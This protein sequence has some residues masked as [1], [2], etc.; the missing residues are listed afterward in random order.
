[1]S[2]PA[3][4]RYLAVSEP[5]FYRYLA[6]TEPRNFGLEPSAATNWSA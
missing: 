5:A 1:V 2:E 4:Y 6:V 3:V